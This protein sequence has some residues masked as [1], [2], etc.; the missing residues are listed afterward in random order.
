MGIFYASKILLSENT[1]DLEQYLVKIP[2]IDQKSSLILALNTIE[3]HSAPVAT[4][5]SPNGKAMGVVFTRMIVQEIVG[6]L[7]IW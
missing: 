3:E 7:P 1:T 5:V 2:E 6:E 4:V